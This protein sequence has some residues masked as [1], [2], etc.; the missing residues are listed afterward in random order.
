MAQVVLWLLKAAPLQVAKVVLC[1]LVLE[2]ARAAQAVRCLRWLDRRLVRA[3]AVAC[4]CL[5]ATAAAS[6]ALCR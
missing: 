4:W 1:G 2:L 5:V 3:L 6:A